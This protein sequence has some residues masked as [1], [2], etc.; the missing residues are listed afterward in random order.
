M[1]IFLSLLTLCVG[2]AGLIMIRGIDQ[3]GAPFGC[4]IL[5]VLF[6]LLIA[7]LNYMS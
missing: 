4:A 1:K 2:T 5:L 3:D 6:G 7:A